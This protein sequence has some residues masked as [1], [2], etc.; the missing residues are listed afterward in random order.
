MIKLLQSL[1]IDVVIVGTTYAAL[2]G[3]MFAYYLLNGLGLCSIII[4][5]LA[6]NQIESVMND[7]TKILLSQKYTK[8]RYYWNFATSI[9]I[10]SFMIWAKLYIA[11]F[12]FL[13]F[14]V[15]ASIIASNAIKLQEEQHNES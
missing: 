10:V 1:L 15:I 12:G 7:S 11:G 2:K 6:F 3:S 9:L 8:L 5:A 13:L 14:F 4:F